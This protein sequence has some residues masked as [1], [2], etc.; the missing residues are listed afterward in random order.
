MKEISEFYV[1]ED[2]EKFYTEQECYEHESKLK[3]Q[4]LFQAL[5]SI[6]DLCYKHDICEDCPFS[7][8]SLCGIVGEDT[9]PMSWHLENWKGFI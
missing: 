2:G 7:M 1:A 5:K 8:G 9:P 3:N 4:N 6:K